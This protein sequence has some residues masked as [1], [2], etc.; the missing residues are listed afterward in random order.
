MAAVVLER[1]RHS[2]LGAEV[3]TIT[4]L[5]SIKREALRTDSSN[6]DSDEINQ[7]ER[8]CGGEHH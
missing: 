7:L 3:I 8:R 5:N 4:L 6:R 2:D 1:I